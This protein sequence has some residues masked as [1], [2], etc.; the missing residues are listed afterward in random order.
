MFLFFFVWNFQ[1]VFPSNPML[2]ECPWFFLLFVYNDGASTLTLNVVVL[3]AS[4]TLSWPAKT[5]WK[6]NMSGLDFFVP[7]LQISNSFN[8]TDFL[9][10]LP[11]TSSWLQGPNSIIVLRCLLFHWILIW[12]VENSVSALFF[13]WNLQI[14]FPSKASFS[15]SP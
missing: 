12:K 3:P 14:V 11:L 6:L 8:L 7:V 15:E 9:N 4:L 2:S 5:T 1:N 13:V 10:L